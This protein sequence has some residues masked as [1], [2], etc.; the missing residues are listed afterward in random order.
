MYIAYLNESLIKLFGIF[1]QLKDYVSAK[2]ARQIYYSFV[3]S[4]ITYGIEFYG[5]C[6]KTSPERVQI[7]Q[8]KLLKLLLWLHL[9]TSTNS[10]HNN[11][12][13]SEI[14]DVYDLSLCVFINR[15]LQGDCPPAL[16]RFLSREIRHTTLATQDSL[17]IVVLV[18]SSAL[19]F[20]TMR[21]NCGIF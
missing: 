15:N 21:P 6:A 12:K 5:S 10:L 13:I 8:N 20:S 19:E 2:L 16:K 18:L 9:L 17:T 4:R 7:L 3:Y 11:M 1:N 14:K